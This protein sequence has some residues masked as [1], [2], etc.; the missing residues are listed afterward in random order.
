MNV[1]WY[2]FKSQIAAVLPEYGCWS[3]GQVASVVVLGEKNNDLL[4]ASA[5][6]LISGLN[7]GLYYN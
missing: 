1:L 2:L 6:A 7:T 4:T 3:Q 5:F